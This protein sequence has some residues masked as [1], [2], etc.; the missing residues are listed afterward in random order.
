MFLI[1][2]GSLLLLRKEK[3]ILKKNLLL[4]GLVAALRSGGQFL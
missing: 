2:L 3:V 1:V 4:R